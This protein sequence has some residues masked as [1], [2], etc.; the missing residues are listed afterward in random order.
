MSRHLRELGDSGRQRPGSYAGVWAPPFVCRDYITATTCSPDELLE[1]TGGLG[2]KV[3][4]RLM[5]DSGIFCE[6]TV[7]VGRYTPVRRA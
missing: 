7:G 3:A 5:P 1:L 4:S 6:I 2:T